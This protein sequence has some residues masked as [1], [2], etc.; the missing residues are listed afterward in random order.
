MS[1]ASTPNS[2]CHQ[3]A[4]QG[5]EAPLCLYVCS[6]ARAS[7]SH[8]YHGSRSQILGNSELEVELVFQAQIEGR[9]Q[10]LSVLIMSFNLPV[11]SHLVSNEALP[12]GDQPCILLE[13]LIHDYRKD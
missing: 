7:T 8:A 6:L 9:Q 5:K 1:F 10:D 11:R 4:V 12:A 3:P 13:L 2:E